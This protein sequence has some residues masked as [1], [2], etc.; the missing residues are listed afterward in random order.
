VNRIVAAVRPIY[1]L[2]GKAENV[3]VEHPDCG[4]D[5]PDDIRQRAYEF[6]ETHLI[7]KTGKRP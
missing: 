7:G 6:L 5:F 1:T 4:H 2:H 3:H